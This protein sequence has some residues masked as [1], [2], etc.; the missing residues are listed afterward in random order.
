MLPF[1]KH[2]A[3]RYRMPWGAAIGAVGSIAAASMS[4]KENGGAGTQ[5]ATKEPWLA[6][7]P[8]ITKNLE[9]GQA[10]QDKYMAQPQSIEQQNAVANIYG[11]SDYMRGLIPSLLGQ[12]GNQQVGFDPSNPTAKP[13]AW[14]WDGLLG[15]A[16]GAPDLGQRSMGT[17]PLPTAPAAAAPK[18]DFVNFEQT[19]ANQFAGAWLNPESTRLLTDGGDA[20]RSQFMG[21]Q[22]GAGFGDYKY[23]M[24]TPAKG[25]KAYRDMQEYIAYGGNDPYGLLSSAVLN[26]AARET[27]YGAATDDGGAAAA[28]GSSANF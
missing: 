20:L 6:A 9:Q 14:K 13:N 26:P 27:G 7:Q 25:T 3:M 8:W 2:G 23:G 4:K 5:T 19:P 1:N 18:G 17:Q 21:A 10:L 16:P 11:Q 24:K 28:V 15:G 12:L 22:G